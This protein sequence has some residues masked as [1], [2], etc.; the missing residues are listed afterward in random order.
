MLHSQL[1][2]VGSLTRVA[3]A[4]YAEDHIVWK[5]D[6]AVFYPFECLNGLT[7]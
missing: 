4:I 7:G 3:F 6:D 5:S 1:G 2:E